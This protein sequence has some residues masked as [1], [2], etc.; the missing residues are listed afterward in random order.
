MADTVVA[1][2]RR[3]PLAAAIAGTALGMVLGGLGL[4]AVLHR[5]AAPPPPPA[6]LTLEDMGHLV[7]VKVRYANVI[8][9]TQQITQGIP[10]TQ[11]ELKLGGTQVLL[12]ARG[13]CLVGADMRQARYEA[14]DA[15]ARTA[16]L[17]LPVPATLSARVDHG[18]R[19]QGGS[20]FY[21]V[22]G[23]GIEPLIPGS[24]HRTQAIDTALQRAQQDVERTC[25]AS[26]T[27][28]T[29]KENAEAVLKPLFAATGWTVQ[30][31]W[32]P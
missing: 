10:W 22:Q 16:V 1:T 14:V 15:A 20:Y 30:V 9:F 29:A 32:Q 4:W 23:T 12:V 21:A 8:E 3:S 18:P 25:Q 28:A 11:W 7:S 27:V 31:R 2:P 17:R 13:D 5:P 24:A 19:D 26:S 6:L